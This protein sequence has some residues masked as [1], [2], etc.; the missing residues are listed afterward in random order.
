[1]IPSLACF[2]RNQY[3]DRQRTRG[4]DAFV[5]KKMKRY[6]SPFFW[7]GCFLSRI[8]YGNPRKVGPQLPT[9]AKQQRKRRCLLGRKRFERALFFGPIQ[10][11]TY[12][13]LCCAETIVGKTVPMNPPSVLSRFPKLLIGML[14]RWEVSS[15]L[16]IVNFPVFPLAQST[17]TNVSP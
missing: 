9:K 11:H 17:I 14:P 15:A 8:C 2:K 3:Q 4:Y 16:T 5:K 12:E 7:R 1:M 13:I 6:F 10:R